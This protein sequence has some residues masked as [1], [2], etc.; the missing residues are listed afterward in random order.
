MIEE[1]KSASMSE[2]KSPERVQLSA[3]Q[4]ENLFNYMAII[5]MQLT[6]K[7]AERT[8]KQM[9]H[10]LHVDCEHYF[11]SGPSHM[12][13]HKKLVRMVFCAGP[14]CFYCLINPTKYR[15]ILGKISLR[16]SCA[17]VAQ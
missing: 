2:E 5:Q 16:N 8:S 14:G 7:N 12:S 10:C 4:R 6:V 17:T 11:S 3:E 15:L 13:L 1:N 9:W